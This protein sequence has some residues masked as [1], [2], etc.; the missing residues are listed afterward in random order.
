MKEKTVRDAAKKL[1]KGSRA[2]FLKLW[3]AAGVMDLYEGDLNTYFI[4]IRQILSDRDC[5]LSGI[6]D[7]IHRVSAQ[8]KSTIPS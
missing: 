1:P 3:G 8:L 2:S 5:K 4:I 7:V 6:E